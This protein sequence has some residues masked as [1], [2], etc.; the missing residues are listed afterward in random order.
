MTSGGTSVMAHRFMAVD[1]GNSA[2]KFGFFDLPALS[3][4][5]SRYP[6]PIDD[7]RDTDETFPNLTAWLDGL[8][9]HGRDEKLNWAVAGVNRR[10]V[11]SFL[12]WLS[13]RRPN[14]GVI[15]IKTADVPMVNRYDQPDRLGVD[16][17]LGAL[18]AWR[19]VSRAVTVVD[20]WTASKIDW[21]DSDGAFRGGAIFPGPQTAAGSLGEKTD[22]LPQVNLDGSARWPA[23][24]TV[25]GILCG[26]H[27]AQIGAVSYCYRAAR[28]KFDAQPPV[29]LTG[30]G[31]R[32]LEEE[33][34]GLIPGPVQTTRDLVLSGIFLTFL[35][36]NSTSH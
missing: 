17:L 31:A 26:I 29:I 10:R 11:T 18:A 25:D 12:D 16:R 27:A 7:R 22:L 9:R 36:L 8:L 33:L 35:A 28:A 21:V 2:W 24:N 1:I 3:A 34:A 23:A 4:L 6:Y 19:M 14:D 20:I 13:A 15:Q 5:G 30:G 32:N